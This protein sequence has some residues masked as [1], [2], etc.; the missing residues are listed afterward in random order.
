MDQGSM[1]ASRPDYYALLGIAADAD[2]EAIRAAYR[3]LAK[4]HHPDLAGDEDSG[5]TARFLEIQEAYD[6]LSDA[7]RRALYDVERRRQEALEE[8]RQ[9]QRD[10][11]DRLSKGPVPPGSRVTIRPMPAAG[12]L[13]KPAATS[14]WLYA[15]AILFVVAVVGLILFQE[16]QK[17]LAAQLDQITVVR[18]DAARRS[19]P[20]DEVR[21]AESA[22]PGLSALAKEKEQ[23][24]RLQASQAEAARLR[25][26]S[27]AQGGSAER[28]VATST[29]PARAPGDQ[30]STD[31]NGKVDCAGE[32]RKFFVI[33][34]ND[35]VSVSYNGGPLMRPTIHDQGAGLIIVS[36]VEPTNRISLGFMKGDRDRTI[37]LISDA[38]GNVF[39]TFGVD[40]SGAA[41]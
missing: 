8:A 24:A 6:V 18:V 39:R 36:M 19:G 1:T 21:R 31:A 37:V 12:P 15:G 17:N 26:E 32:G 40:C 14:S 23:F 10:L 13:P 35:I 3:A 4:Q 22:P 9:L 2:G 7:D 20:P 33:R 25:A 16:R 28:K 5:S 41:F 30:P 29:P 34:Q 27:Q 38:V 11:A